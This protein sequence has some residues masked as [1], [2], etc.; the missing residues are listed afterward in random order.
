MTVGI[1]LLIA[2]P[3]YGLGMLTVAMCRAR[4]R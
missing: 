4:A 3:A 2:F 1:G